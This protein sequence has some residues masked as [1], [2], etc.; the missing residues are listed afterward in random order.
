MSVERPSGIARRHG[1]TVAV[2][3]AGLGYALIASSTRPF[4]VAA[5]IVTAVPLAVALV[6]TI[7]TMR[8]RRWSYA[9]A[10]ARGET[11]R[12]PWSRRWTVWLA[13]IVAIGAW[14]LYCFVSVPRVQHPTLSVLIDSL[15]SSR[16]GKT[17][18]FASW[19]SLG[20]FL[21]AR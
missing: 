7:R 14:E 21:V 3:T 16:I 6:L 8:H 1:V 5:D 2:S 17:V 20:W 11:D 15:D 12:P 18:A 9:V 19:L 4:T 13:P 10:S